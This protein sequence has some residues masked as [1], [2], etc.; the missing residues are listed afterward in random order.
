MISCS[1]KK[2]RIIKA[3]MGKMECC[4][5]GHGCCCGMPRGPLSGLVCH[6]KSLLVPFSCFLCIIGVRSLKTAFSILLCLQSFS[7]YYTNEKLLC[8]V[9][10]VEQKCLVPV[11]R[12]VGFSRQQMWFL[13]VP[14]Q[15]PFMNSPSE[16]K[17]EGR[18]KGRK[19]WKKGKKEEE[20]KEKK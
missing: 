15:E 16:R 6:L 2:T 13:S 3:P 7:W 14:S 4:W 17:E 8:E 11:S 10:K 9:W 20:K 18:E 12:S 1:I 19:G 5:Q